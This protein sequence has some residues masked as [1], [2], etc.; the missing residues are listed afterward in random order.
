MC[1]CVCVP[2]CLSGDGMRGTGGCSLCVAISF[3]SIV[4]PGGSLAKNIQRGMK[5]S[6][7]PPRPSPQPQKE[8]WRLAFSSR[9]REHG[10]SSQG[11]CKD[12]WQPLSQHSAAEI[13]WPPGHRDALAPPAHSE[14]STHVIKH[15]D[16]WCE[17]PASHALMTHLLP[18]S[19]RGPARL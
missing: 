7:F 9:C 15:N 18:S 2:V 1:V 5:D 11:C 4:C 16:T 13:P 14:A 6:A 3:Y 17:L 10:P 19:S 12:L 8:A